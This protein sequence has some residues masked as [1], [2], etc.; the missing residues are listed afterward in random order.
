MEARAGPGGG[1]PA[2]ALALGRP[3][4]RPELKRGV[5]PASPR[6]PFLSERGLSCKEV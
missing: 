4:E 5:S 3:A 6:P 2:G 1:G